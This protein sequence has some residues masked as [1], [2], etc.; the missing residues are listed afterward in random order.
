[1]ITAI[2][3]SVLLLIQK[4]QAGW[5]D[6]KQTLK[7]A[8]REGPL[9][10]CPVVFAEYS[11]GYE[12]WSAA[13]SDL[14][15]LQISYE[16]IAPDTAWLAGQVF[17]QYRK[18]GGPRKTLIPDFLIAAHASVQADRLAALDRGYLRRFFPKLLLLIPTPG[19]S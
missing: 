7:H 6:W 11:P 4:R 8:S 17:L 15:L 16:P 1:M 2:D 18:E 13:M 9:V 10:V 14:D 19:R 3:T 5:M 12:C